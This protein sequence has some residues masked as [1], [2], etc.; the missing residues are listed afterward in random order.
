MEDLTAAPLSCSALESPIEP[1]QEYL[2]GN[3]RE[4][5]TVGAMA[6][7]SGVS[8][9][10]LRFYEAKGLLSPRREGPARL[11][12]PVETERLALILK[13]K[14]L[15]FTLL[16]IRDMLTAPGDPGRSG[17]L[18][19]SRRQC[20]EQIRHLE[21]RKSEIESALVELRRTYSS[22]YVRMVEFERAQTR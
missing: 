13:A 14:R 2:F 1:E 20:I 9:R 18:S 17:S 6:R 12:G 15:G 4:F 21:Q 7:R 16:E 19:L 8:E 3:T 10:A 5:L 11:Y 22:F